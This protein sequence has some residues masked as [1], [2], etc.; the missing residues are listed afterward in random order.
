MNRDNLELS[1]FALSKSDG[2]G[3]VLRKVL[4]MADQLQIIA[5]RGA[6]GLAPENTLSAF[7]LAVESGAA[8]IELDVHL[9][10]DHHLAVIHDA[11]VNRTTNGQ[12]AVADFTL[13]ELQ[14]LDAGSWFG[15]EFS[16]AQIPALT[17]VIQGVGGR[18]RLNIEVKQVEA[19]RN[20]RPV[21]AVLLETLEAAGAAE[22]HLISSF[23]WD[24]LTRIYQLAP[25]V[26]LA[27]LFSFLPWNLRKRMAGGMLT[28]I[29]PRHP[30]VSGRLIKAAHAQ[31]L[32][33]NVWTVDKP[34]RMRKLAALGVDGI[35]T[36]FPERG[37]NT[38]DLFH[39]LNDHHHQLHQ[40]QP[41][42]N[43]FHE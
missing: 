7:N 10:R 37:L 29:H 22:S 27:Y 2:K 9:T 30:I 14:Q 12:G 20:S 25:Q 36:N 11:T 41:Q 33:V 40:D 26:K 15:P 35:I 18:C 16:G 6:S 24:L 43:P 1:L 5:H 23:D 34:E 39:Q 3:V 8:M 21:E 38:E 19:G 17:E 28:A 31:G 4:T 42:D 32:Q 13:A